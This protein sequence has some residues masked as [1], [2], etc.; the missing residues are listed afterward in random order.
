MQGDSE[1]VKDVHS[2]LIL[3]ANFFALTCN[4]RNLHQNHSISP[5]PLLSQTEDLQVQVQ[6]P[7]RFFFLCLRILE[8]Q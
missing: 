8:N 1:A 3:S 6:G 4:E 7:F 2:F 5:A